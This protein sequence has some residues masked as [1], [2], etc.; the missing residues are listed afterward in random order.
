MNK[1]DRRA[2]DFDV[3]RAYERK[4]APR[5][6]RECTC[7]H[8]WYSHRYLGKGLRCMVVGCPCLDYKEK[9]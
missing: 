1:H 3:V 7:T 5:P 4:D 2:I 8:L 9:K 6:I